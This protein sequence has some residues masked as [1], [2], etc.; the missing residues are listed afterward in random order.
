MSS[1]YDFWLLKDPANEAG[2]H[3]G[4]LLLSAADGRSITASGVV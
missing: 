4:R 1:T 2:S 3:C